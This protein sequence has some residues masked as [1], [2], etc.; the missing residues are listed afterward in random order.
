MSSQTTVD[1][2]SF[3]SLVPSATAGVAIW[4]VTTSFTALGWP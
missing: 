4:S 3:T 2:A 1:F